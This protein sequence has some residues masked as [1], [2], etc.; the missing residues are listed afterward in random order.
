MAKVRWGEEE[1]A[2]E[3]EKQEAEIIQG[4]STAEHEHMDTCSVVKTS[5]RHIPQ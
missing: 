3:A 5:Y 1:K 4:G 2:R